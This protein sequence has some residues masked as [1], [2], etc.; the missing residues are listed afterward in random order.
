[1]AGGVSAK[2]IGAKSTYLNIKEISISENVQKTKVLS[3]NDQYKELEKTILNGDFKVGKESFIEMIDP[4]DKTPVQVLTTVI[5]KDGKP[6]VMGVV[7]KNGESFAGA[8]IGESS[9]TG[10]INVS[11]TKIGADKKIVTEANKIQKKCPWWSLCTLSF[12]YRKTLAILAIIS[13]FFFLII[14]YFSHKF[15]IMGYLSLF[16]GAFFVG[17]SF[18]LQMSRYDIFKTFCT[19]C[20]I[21][22]IL[23]CF[24]FMIMLYEFI[25][26]PI[27][28]NNP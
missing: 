27:W 24:I 28:K 7:T 21:T 8:I 10:G 18:F 17:F 5:V 1:M 22:T 9:D 19:N 16:C 13:I 11:V 2:Q 23:Y 12:N 6:G 14:Y 20:I 25:L 4:S 15:K 26:Q 3:E